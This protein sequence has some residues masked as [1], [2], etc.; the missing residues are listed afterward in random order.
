MIKKEK[1]MRD[2]TSW[3]VLTKTV[4]QVKT[5]GD[6]LDSRELAS[7]FKSGLFSPVRPFQQVF[8]MLSKRSESRLVEFIRQKECLLIGERNREDGVATRPAF[9]FSKGE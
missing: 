3:L 9:L 6:M 7:P 8:T 4:G 2:A 5:G 1:M